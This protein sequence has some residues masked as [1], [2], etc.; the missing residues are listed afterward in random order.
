MQSLLQDVRYALRQLRRNPGFTLVAVLTLTLGIGANT[1]IFSVIDA[2]LLRPLPYPDPGRLVTLYNLDETR[3]TDAIGP[4]DVAIYRDELHLFAALAAY[5]EQPFTLT[6]QD[7]PERVAGA[8]ASPQFFDVLGVRAKMGRTL[9]PE[10]DKP[11]SAPVVVLSAS[12]W[13]RR[14]GS[15][16]AIVGKNIDIDGEP[17]TVVGVMPEGFAF[18]AETEMWASSKFGLP[19]HPLTPNVDPSNAR[20]N[21][22]LDIVGRLAPG[23]SL[24][25]AA[26]AADTIHARLKKQFGNEEGGKGAT[27]ISL[28]EDLVGSDRPAL[29]IL[30]GAVALLLLIACANVASVLL[31]RGASRQREFA[32]RE[33]LG[34]GRVRIVRQLITETLML[35]MVGGAL[36]IFVAWLALKPMSALVPSDAG[37]SLQ[38]DLRLLLF[39]VAISIG[40][41]ILF[42]LFPAL[43]LANSGI[44]SGLREGGRGSTGIHATKLRSV[45]VTAEIALSLVLLMGAGLLMRSFSK[46]LGEP[47]GFNPDRVLSMQV[48]LPKARYQTPEQQAAFVR[49]VLDR[50]RAV[51]GISSAAVISRLPLL[52]GASTRDVDLVGKP[53]PPGTEVAPDYVVVSPEYFTTLGVGLLR[54]RM[55]TEHDGMPDMP[56]AVV[57]ESFAQHFWPGE[58]PIGK[59]MMV[60]KCSD[61]APGSSC[62]VVGVV[63]DVKQHELG[64]AVRPIVYV[65]YARDPWPFFSLVLRT[66]MEPTSAAGSVTAAIRSVDKALPVYRVQ[67]MREVVARSLSPRRLRMFLLGG[68]AGLALVLACVGIYGVMAYSV[69]Q[70]EHEIGIRMAMGANKNDVLGLIA[71]QALVLAL[72][73]IAV[74]IGLSLVTGRLL[75][76]VLYGVG[77]SDP[78]T[79]L[80]SSLLLIAVAIGASLAPALRA[81]QVDP[82]VALRVD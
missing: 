75:T 10:I 47:E 17:H 18:P 79:L 24:Q 5:R 63:R 35:S 78:V 28:R 4:A 60:G 72:S 25:Q 6:G 16:P 13:Q 69:V 58:D 53:N 31:A 12:V 54:G 66:K 44:N 19:P 57:S 51:P 29:L 40:S 11:G 49:E 30:L 62:E 45:V 26:S 43:Q 73:G 37:N 59:R 67:T 52:P 2:V 82:M 48:S 33:A 61:A 55:F 21:H 81:A 15:D 14:F 64:E 20:D 68:F 9:I 36:G 71:R 8:V 56:V 3:H 50:A 39:T 38:L 76:S 34:A 23:V 41:G 22:Y 46:L 74:G 42:G 65:P 77:A 80:A 32:I 7:L 1:A 70:R 27:V